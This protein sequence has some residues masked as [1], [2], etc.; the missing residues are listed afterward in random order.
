[1]EEELSEHFNLVHQGM[2]Q[3]SRGPESHADSHSGM[4]IEVES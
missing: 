4:E 2:L 1:M 3:D